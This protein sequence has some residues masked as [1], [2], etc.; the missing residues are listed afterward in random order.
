MKI[1]VINKQKTVRPGI[2]QIKKLTKH[3]I[4]AASRLSPDKKWGDVSVVLVDDAGMEPFN[5]RLF[6]KND[7]TD[8]ISQCYAPI[9]GDDSLWTADV[10]VNVETA[11]DMGTGKKHGGS[12]WDVQREI[13]LYIAHGCDHLSGAEDSDEK[14]RARMRSR[15]LR[16]LNQADSEGLLKGLL[17]L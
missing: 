15:E 12:S 5:R 2:R 14:G 11:V 8:V 1:Q 10:I 9:P 4:S 13:A 17:L 7:T 6:N 16:W 3:L